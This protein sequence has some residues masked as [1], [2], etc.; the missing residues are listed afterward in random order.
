MLIIRFCLY[1]GKIY[2]A[3][4][5][6]S[7]IHCILI[8]GLPTGILFLCDATKR[9]HYSNMKQAVPASVACILALPL[10]AIVVYSGVVPIP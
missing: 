2:I 10:I 9:R 6:V 1:N 3:T 8:V 4:F 5:I 7:I